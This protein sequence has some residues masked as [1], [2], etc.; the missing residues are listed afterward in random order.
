MGGEGEGGIHIGRLYR[1]MHV[2]GV[3]LRNM[4]VEELD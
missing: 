3:K 1:G 2:V 4:Y